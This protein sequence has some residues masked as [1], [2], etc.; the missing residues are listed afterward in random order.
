MTKE[1][2]K[3]NGGAKAS[4]RKTT[5]KSSPEK[6]RAA[7]EKAFKKT[8]VEREDELYPPKIID[9]ARMSYKGKD[10]SKMYPSRVM[11]HADF[12]DADLTDADLSGFNLQGAIFQNTILTNTDFS[13]ADLRWAIFRNCQDMEE[14]IF[15]DAN[16]MEATY[17]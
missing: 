14:A 7:L 1:T 6:K 8:M 5:R 10:M 17:Q 4:P 15:E 11:K 2:L 16:A 3:L 13:G 9:Q 12:T